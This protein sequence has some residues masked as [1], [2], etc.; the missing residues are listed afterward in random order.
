MRTS[1]QPDVQSAP[2]WQV[3]LVAAKG[4]PVKYGEAP[5]SVVRFRI[6][7]SDPNNPSEQPKV[8]Q[9]Q[10][11]HRVAA[12]PSQPDQSFAM[13]TQRLCV[14]CHPR[15]HRPVNASCV[16]AEWYHALSLLKAVLRCNQIIGQDMRP[17][18]QPGFQV[19]HHGHQERPARLHAVGLKHLPH[20]R[21]GLSGRGDDYEAMN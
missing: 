9:V 3:T 18:L 12:L 20:G 10:V 21:Q 8:S 15:L 1:Q 7:N 19:Q 11:R 13:S 4:L 16:T 2:V 17:S 6:L 5:S 14:V